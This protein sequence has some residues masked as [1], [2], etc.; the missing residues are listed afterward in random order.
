MKK[1]PR[2]R[3]LRHALAALVLLTGFAAQAADNGDVEQKR[4][5]LEEVR[6]RIR[7]L[8]KEIADTEESRSS[9]SEELAEAERAVSRVQRE[10][11]QLAGNRTAAEKNLAVLEAERQA[12]EERIGSRQS[13]LAEWL[14]QHYVHCAAGGVAPF[15]STRDP[16]Q[17]ARDA[18]YLEYLG[19]ARLELIET[20][21]ADL[22]EKK[23]LGE[24]IAAR[25]DRLVALEAEQQV[26]RKELEAVQVRRK[27]AVAG[28]AEQLRSQR[29]EERTLRQDQERLGRLVAVLARRA[30]EREAARAAAAAKA[31]REQ[32]ARELAARA[33]AAREQ[34][35]SERAARDPGVP[36]ASGAG[37]ADTTV[38]PAVAAEAKPARTAQARSEP[39]VGEIRQSAGPTPTGVSFAQLRGKMRF[40]V[41]GELLGRFGAPRAEGG[42]TW[43]GVF[44]RAAGGT[45]VRAVAAGEVVF[46]D[47]L[48]GYGNL[49]IVDHGGDYL[50]IYG[51]NDA[52]LKQLGDN[53]AGGD[54]IASVGT[55][56]GGSDSGLYFE[57]RHRG[58]PLDPLKWVQVN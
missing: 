25:R 2:P 53:I 56:G 46:S 1:I 45:Q 34:A 14:R 57:I 7:D 17:L 36:G 10:L 49:I 20:L 48:R 41:R 40:P 30:A 15:L 31:A 38:S 11:Q 33:K 5:D 13:E 58:Q 50:T 18:Y 29:K 47:W 54:A 51:N 27:E 22:K 24:S 35:A 26:R 32:A 19:K 44:I 21:R 52:L 6:Q 3:C 12:V 16:N 23:R 55:S 43:R 42:T 9:A 8:Q 37:G 39:V 4:S 28:L